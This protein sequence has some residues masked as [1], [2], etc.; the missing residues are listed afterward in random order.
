LVPA[1]QRKGL[2]Q[3]HGEVRAAPRRSVPAVNEDLPHLY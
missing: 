1:L 2:G 3:E